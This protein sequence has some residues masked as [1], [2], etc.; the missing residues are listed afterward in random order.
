LGLV[1]SV[2]S[3][4]AWAISAWHSSTVSAWAGEAL[5]HISNE[6]VSPN[7]RL[8]PIL[9]RTFDTSFSFFR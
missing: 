7:K 6:R 9:A 5:T 1:V 2:R 8:T 4:L 3:A